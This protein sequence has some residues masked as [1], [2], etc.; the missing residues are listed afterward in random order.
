MWQVCFCLL[1]CVMFPS[2]KILC[3]CLAFPNDLDGGGPPWTL[4]VTQAL[5]DEFSVGV[6]WDEWGIDCN[7]VVSVIKYQI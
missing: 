7:V 6:L 4:E 1:L 2:L 3:R 5:T